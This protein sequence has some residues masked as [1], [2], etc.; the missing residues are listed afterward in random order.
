MIVTREN[1]KHCLGQI[2]LTPEASLDTETTGLRPY[3][4]D[5]LFSVIIANALT[6]LY[7]NFQ[8]Y[9]GL[10]P[11]STLLPEHLH[12]LQ[13]LFSDPHRVWYLHNAKYDM[14]ILAVEGLEL[15]GTIHCCKSTERIIFNDYLPGTYDL[16]S[17]AARRGLSKD[18]AVERYIEE[19]ALWDWTPPEKPGK[20]EKLPHYEKVPYSIIVPY[21]EC[22]GGITFS[23]ATRQEKELQD[24]HL[25]NNSLLPSIF[26][27]HKNEQ[28]LIKTIH[29]ME[30]RGVLIDKGYC[31]RA[32]LWENG[33]VQKATEEFKRITGQDFKASGKLFAHVFESERDK[34]H[35]TKAGNPSFEC[36]AL[37]TFEN[38]AAREVLT[39]RDAKSRGD[40]YRGFLYH[41][42]SQGVIHPTFD[43]AGAATGRFSSSAPNFQNLTSE[44]EEEQLAQEFVVRRAIIPRPGFVLYGR[45]YKQMEYVMTADYAA[46]MWGSVTEMVQRIRR[47]EDVHQATADIVT[48][49][50]TPLTR[51][52]AKNVNFAFLYGSGYDTLAATAGCS[53]AEAIALKDSVKAA[54]PEVQKLIENVSVTARTKGFIRNWAGRIS[55]LQD[56]N[57]AYAMT[58]YLIQGG[59]ADVNKFALN[60]VDEYLLGMKS[61]LIMTIHDEMVLEL[62]ESE[63]D[64]VP[65]KIKELMDTVYPGKYLSLGSSGYIGQN[66]ADIED[67]S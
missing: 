19:H 6:T 11:E 54:L 4:G 41:A 25:A 30:K 42:D 24:I 8:C 67:H 13:A 3:H 2:A 66:L 40:F 37:G 16:D 64:V 63:V 20:R 52:R 55:H 17:C 27:I 59:C 39:Y 35:F 58:N 49:G 15:A 34:W 43:P 38:P 51:K 10:P 29:R 65:Q 14:S 28:R 57:F 5:R 45:D 46:R 22:D 62:H 33:R 32:A 36:D 7:F 12:G 23:L 26:N 61:R 56:R 21:G 9:P 48:A 60:R 47:G 50:G 18:K 44:E 31:V 53:R 1:Y